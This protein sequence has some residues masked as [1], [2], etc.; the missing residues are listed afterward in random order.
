MTPYWMT[1]LISMPDRLAATVKLGEAFLKASPAERTA[2]AAGWNFNVQWDAPSPW[3]LACR[4]GEVG[5]P[6][7]RIVAALV[8]TS[9]EPS[10]DE[11]DDLIFL[12][13]ANAVPDP[14][15]THLKQFVA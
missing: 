6:R 9:L 13:V 1:E 10:P 5:S 14:I 4:A 8:L 11:R 2:V 12:S 15:A 7:E 3:R